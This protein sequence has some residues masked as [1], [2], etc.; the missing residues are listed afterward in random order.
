LSS[1]KL[2]VPREGYWRPCHVPSPVWR[3][4]KGKKAYF[5]AKAKIRT[6]IFGFNFVLRKICNCMRSYIKTDYLAFCSR[7][8]NA[9]KRIST[10]CLNCNAV[11]CLRNYVVFSNIRIFIQYLMYEI[12]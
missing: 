11:I 10:L 8:P 3:G 6:L 7:Y 1:E 4:S 12:I 9:L 5:S 2:D